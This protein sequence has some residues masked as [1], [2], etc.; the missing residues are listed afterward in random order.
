MIQIILM[1][2]YLI[3]KMK[4]SGNKIYNLKI[5][6]KLTNLFSKWLIIKIKKFVQQQ[7]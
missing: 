5:K 2:L 6:Y 3:Q 1:Y 7:N 4:K